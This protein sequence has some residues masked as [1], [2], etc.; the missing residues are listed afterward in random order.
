MTT[1]HPTTNGNHVPADVA[2]RLLQDSSPYLSCD[3]CFDRIDTYVEQLL[4]DPSYHDVPMQV[5]LK[6]C[7]V[8]ADEAETLMELLSS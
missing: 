8:C 3:E 7:G 2:N 4:K 1:E 6:S 5:H